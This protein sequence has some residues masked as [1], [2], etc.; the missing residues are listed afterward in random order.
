MQ[1]KDVN[2]MNRKEREAFLK[3]AKRMKDG[4]GL[5]MQQSMKKLAKIL[6]ESD[7]KKSR[8]K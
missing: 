2:T 7:N 3:T 1:N 8:S 4:T 6:N 5:T